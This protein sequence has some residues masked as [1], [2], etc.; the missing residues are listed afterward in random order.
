MILSLVFALA[1][2]L[3]PCIEAAS[4]IAPVSSARSQD[5]LD[6]VKR[7]VFKELIGI[8]R[9][10]VG[11]TR[12]DLLNIFEPS[13]GLSG[14]TGGCFVHRKIPQ[15]KLDVVF[16]P[17][18]DGPPE[19][20]REDFMQ[21]SDEKIPSFTTT[22]LIKA[23]AADCIV[24]SNE[25]SEIESLN[26]LLNNPGLHSKFPRIPLAKEAEDLM[27]RESTISSKERIQLNRLILEAAYPL[28][29]PKIRGNKYYKFFARPE[30]RIIKISKPYLESWQ[31]LD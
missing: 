30:D 10:K 28:Q 31:I 27:K 8:E 1:L 21:Y 12:A 9:I 29:C 15:V 2:I 20:I 23:L 14:R 4:P 13:G 3:V 22:G 7:W 26:R 24:L 25:G 17:V 18:N 16:E 6:F 11:S 5:D 19:F